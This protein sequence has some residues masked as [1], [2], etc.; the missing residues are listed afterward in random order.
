MVTRPPLPLFVDYSRHAML[1]R[2]ISRSRSITNLLS[3][4]VNIVRMRVRRSRAPWS[5]GLA[6]IL[7]NENAFEL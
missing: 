1:L 7:G 5:R 4:Q 3:D 2:C 6:H